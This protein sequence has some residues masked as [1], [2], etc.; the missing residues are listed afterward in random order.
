[1]QII[2][3]I[4]LGAIDVNTSGILEVEDDTSLAETLE[5]VK[6]EVLKSIKLSIELALD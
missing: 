1:M 5:A 4:D 3:K 6:A 2:W